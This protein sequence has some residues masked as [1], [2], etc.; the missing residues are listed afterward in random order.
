[1][2]TNREN[3]LSTAYYRGYEV[4]KGR[5]SWIFDG[6]TTQETYR[7]FLKLY[8]DCDLPDDFMPPAPLSGEW[9]GESIPELLGDLIDGD[10]YFDEQVMDAYEEGY[11]QGWWDEL[12]S[13]ATSSIWT[14]SDN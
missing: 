5:A 9:A 13:T 11:E 10:D 7:T 14:E 6:N 8:D 12:V 4:G 1:M 2:A 3:V